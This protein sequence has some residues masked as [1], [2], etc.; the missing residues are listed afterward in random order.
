MYKRQGDDPGDF[1]YSVNDGTVTVNGSTD[2]SINPVNDPPVV[3]SSSITV[4][5][6]STDTSLGLAAPTDEDGD[7]LTITVTGLPTLGTVTKGDGTVVNNGD[8]LTSA[9]L[10]GLLY[11]APAEYNAGDDPG[12]FTY[13]VNDGTVTVDGSTD[14]SINPLG[15]ELPVVDSSCL[16]Y[17]SPSPRDYAAS[18]MPSSA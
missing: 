18:R 7:S 8:T 11:D 14:I 12:D 13:S 9:E 15:N 4:D 1:T 16:L 2:I 5:E 10:E 17:T 3:N 6:E